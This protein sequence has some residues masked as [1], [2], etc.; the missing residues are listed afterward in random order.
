MIKKD[1][2]AGLFFMPEK[3]WINIASS[4]GRLVKMAKSG[5]LL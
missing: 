1:P 4:H 5:V 3:Q 2:L